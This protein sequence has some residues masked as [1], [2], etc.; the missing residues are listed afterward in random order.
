MYKIHALGVVFYGEK[1][2]E[3][4][5]KFAHEPVWFYTY[6]PYSKLEQQT[7]AEVD[8]EFDASYEAPPV[9]APEV[10]LQ[11]VN[12]FLAIYEP[13]FIIVHFYVNRSRNE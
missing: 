12:T 5:M 8:E 11:T 9:L 13:L 2:I 7:Q 10:S 4:H 6:G 1:A 3:R